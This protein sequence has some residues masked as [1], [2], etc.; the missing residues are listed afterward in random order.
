MPSLDTVHGIARA[1]GRTGLRR[2]WSACLDRDEKMGRSK[3]SVLAIVYLEPL[4][5][6]ECR[7]CGGWAW[8]CARK[9]LPKFQVRSRTDNCKV[10]GFSTPA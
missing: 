2:D 5:H 8:S 10:H 9:T 4:D 1:E 7:G 6:D 3:S